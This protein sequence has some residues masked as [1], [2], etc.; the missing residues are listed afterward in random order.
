MR[1]G[2][3]SE[4]MR[5]QCFATDRFTLFGRLGQ[6]QNFFG[7]TKAN[8]DDIAKLLAALKAH[9]RP[10][11]PAHLGIIG[12]AHLFRCM[13]QAG[14]DPKT[15]KY[16]RRLGETDGVPRVVEFAFGIHRDGLGSGNGPSRKEV[17]GADRG[18][19]VD[20]ALVTGGAGGIGRAIG[21]GWTQSNWR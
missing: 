16:E 4:E 5:R 8:T 13:E 6:T 12:K 18:A 1:D 7:L 3:T 11:P 17:T 9:T 20:V 14:G 2:P 10:V 19:P 21:P 15:F